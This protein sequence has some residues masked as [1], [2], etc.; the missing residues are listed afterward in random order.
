[1]VCVATN[2]LKKF[3]N[4]LWKHRPFFMPIAEVLV[5][6]NRFSYQETK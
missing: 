3:N 4:G 2:H 5:S 1:M 6:T